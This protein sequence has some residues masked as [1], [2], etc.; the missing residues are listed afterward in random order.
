[1]NSISSKKI[2]NFFYSHSIRGR[3]GRKRTKLEQAADDV[4]KY[5]DLYEPED[6]PNRLFYHG[7]LDQEGSFKK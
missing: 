2:F 6:V 7:G 5:T 4:I 1:M 3:G